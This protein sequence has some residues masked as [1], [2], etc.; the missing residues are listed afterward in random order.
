MAQNTANSEIDGTETRSGI[1]DSIS[2]QAKWLFV[3]PALLYAIVL[4]VYP[5]IDLLILS[6]TG[7]SWNFVGFEN[8]LTVLSDSSFQLVLSNTVTYVIPSTIIELVLGTLL[9]LAFYRQFPLKSTVQTI[10]L[11]PMVL[12][13][14]AVGLMFQ[15]FFR[16]SLGVINYFLE[17]AGLQTYVW[18]ADTQLA[19]IAVIIADVWQWTPFIFLMVYAGLQSVPESH[20]EAAKIDGAGRLQRFRYVILPHI[21]PLLV[22]TSLIKLIIG[23]KNSDKIVAMTGGGPGSQTKT[24]SMFINELTF[25]FNSPSEGA[26][27]SVIFLVIVLFIGNLFLILLSSVS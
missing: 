8:Y 1:V 13:P 23:L 2:N 18:L 20:I 24:L 3:L 4:A 12:T 27:A 26:A 5:L 7:T 9:A 19:M 11:L 16:G 14:F 25:E 15:W 22:I 21:Y 10:F 6:F 17:S